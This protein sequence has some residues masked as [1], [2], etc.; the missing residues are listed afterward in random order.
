MELK[1]RKIFCCTPV[2]FHANA[3]FWIRDTGLIST[4]LREMGV[5]SKCIMPLPHYDDDEHTE[6]LI[7]TEYSHLSSVSWWRSLGI[8]AVILY[9]WGAP[10]YTLIARAIRKAGIKLIVH[11]DMPGVFQG[12]ASGTL[13]GCLNNIRINIMRRIHLHYAHVFSAS[14]PLIDNMR[15]SWYY[16]RS[17]ADKAYEF[18]TPVASHFCMASEKKEYLVTCVGRWSDN[19]VDAVKRPEFCIKTAQA[20]VKLDPDVVVEIY[21]PVGRTMVQIHETTSVGKERI[22]LKGGITNRD[23]PSVYRRAMVNYCP[24]RSEGTHISSAE[25]LS[26]G[27]SIAV[28]PRRQLSLIHW[29][30]SKNSGTI[31]EEDTPDS[32]AKAISSELYAWKNGMRDAVQIAE[33]WSPSF[34]VNLA[35]QNMLTNF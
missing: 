18:P 17:I 20:L 28:T 19:E 3:G 10:R 23:L 30:T 5:E 6:H 13:W 26:C 1:G 4:S 27:C 16:G 8:D 31:S 35:V 25:A 34:A 22:L 11:L 14:K 33:T 9:S 12:E 15:L 21:G 24:S 29:Y 32:L 2:A 7:R